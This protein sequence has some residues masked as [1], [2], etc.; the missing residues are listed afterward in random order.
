MSGYIESDRPEFIAAVAQFAKRYADVTH[1]DQKRL[2]KEADEH[3][4]SSP[5]VSKP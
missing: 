3:G 1:N 4:K 2:K 5:S